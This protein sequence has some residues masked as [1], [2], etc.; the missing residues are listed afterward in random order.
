MQSLFP[1]RY[2]QL[3]IPTGSVNRMREWIRL[4]GRATGAGD[5]ADFNRKFGAAGLV[6]IYYPFNYKLASCLRQMM[7]CE[8]WQ[9]PAAWLQD[10]S[11]AGVPVLTPGGG[12]WR[13]ATQ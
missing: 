11:N 5:K 10:I 9:D 8:P 12:L 13:M 7:L 2:A 1:D 6:D 3:W 4:L